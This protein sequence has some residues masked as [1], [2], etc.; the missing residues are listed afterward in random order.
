MLSLKI[1]C[2]L[3]LIVPNSTSPILA[4]PATVRNPS[5]PK[6][7]KSPANSCIVSPL[8][9]PMSRVTDVT[10]KLALDSCQFKYSSFTKDK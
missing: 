3:V 2:T 10:A 9:Q 5:G 6:N 8:I 1:D 4:V 7:I